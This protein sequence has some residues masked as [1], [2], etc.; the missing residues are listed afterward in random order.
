MQ[1]ATFAA[2]CF[3]GIEA[4]FAR[5]PGV[6]ETAV[7]YEGGQL[8]QPTYEDVCND[9]TGHAE[10]VQVT[11]DPAQVSF[12]QLLEVFWKCHDPT[13][14]NRQGPDHGSQY[15]SAIFTHSEEQRLQAQASLKRHQPG[16]KRPIVTA[17]VPA[18]TFWRG[19]E[20]HQRY[21]QKQGREHCHLPTAD[22]NE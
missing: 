7:G 15:R 4:T 16:F 11:F 17:I 13:T 21:L 19:E 1:K 3:W 2:G 10:V 8:E 20:Y 9:D 6:S 14:L 22:H 5:V 12:D 18:Q